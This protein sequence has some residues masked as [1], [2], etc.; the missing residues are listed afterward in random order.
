MCSLRENQ[1]AYLWF[2]Y[3]SK[4]CSTSVN[5][6]KQTILWPQDLGGGHSLC[7]ALECHCSVVDKLFSATAWLSFWGFPLHHLP[8]DFSCFSLLFPRFDLPIISSSHS[9]VVSGE[10][11]HW[12]QFCKNLT[13]MK[14]LLI[15]PSSMNDN[16]AKYI[17]LIWKF[18]PL[19]LWWH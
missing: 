6:V 2:V 8:A 11:V 15:L 13:N 17:I 18:F 9:S 10:R 7:T 12:E 4:W 14:I 3:F 1:A 16:F 5:S 19:E